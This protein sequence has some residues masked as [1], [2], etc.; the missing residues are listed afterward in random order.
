MDTQKAL[1]GTRGFHTISCIWERD[2]VTNPVEIHY[3]SGAS[4]VGDIN[5]AGLL[6]GS[7]TYRWPTG[8]SY[9]GEFVSGAAHGHGR[10][11]TRDGRVWDGTFSMN[12]GYGVTV[13]GS[14]EPLA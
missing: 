1:E 2:H 4:Y 12:S 9:E 8:E 13:L 10:F 6:H 5:E 3:A 14:A 7:G 11:R